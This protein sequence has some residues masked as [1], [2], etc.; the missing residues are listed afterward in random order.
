[1][2]C[3]PSHPAGEPEI[4]WVCMLL[5]GF[6]VRRVASDDK[7]FMPRRH[8]ART[9]LHRS[10]SKG[11]LLPGC[12]F[13]SIVGLFSRLLQQRKLSF[14]SVDGIFSTSPD[15]PPRDNPYACT[16]CSIYIHPSVGTGGV[17]CSPALRLPGD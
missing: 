4:R 9:L 11:L 15:V 3:R 2:G 5:L 10:P 16:V 7:N 1:M 6:S 14:R 8:Q 13:P 17:A 12:S